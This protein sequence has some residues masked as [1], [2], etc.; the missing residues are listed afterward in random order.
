MPEHVAASREESGIQSSGGPA[1]TGSGALPF[2]S[3]MVSGQVLTSRTE[4]LEDYLCPRV[5][6]LLVVALGGAYHRGAPAR[7]TEYRLGAKFREWRIPAPAVNRGSWWSPLGLVAVFSN[8]AWQILRGAWRGGRD[9]DLFVG[10]SCFS[11][12]IGVVLKSLGWTRR[13]IY[14]SIDYYPLPSQRCFNRLMVRAFYAADRLCSRRADLVWHI[15]ARISE[16]REQYGRLPPSKYRQVEVPLCYREGIFRVLSE[17]HVERWTLGFVGTITE[18]QGLDLLLDA[19]PEIARRC[20]GIS[21]RIIGDGPYGPEFRRRAAMSPEGRRLCF[22]GFLRRE[23]DVLG[24]LGRC[25][26]GVALWPPDEGNNI[27]YADPGKPKLYLAVGLPCIITRGAE[28]AEIIHR[29]GAG[30]AIEYDVTDLVNAVMKVLGDDAAWLAFRQRAQAVGR[31]WTSEAI[32]GRGFAALTA[33]EQ[34]GAGR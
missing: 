29:E 27:R 32:L 7:C 19:M 25:A 26:A 9:F 17:E 20:P 34:G 15:T 23:E 30:V 4:T 31:R 11:G 5:D 14:Y 33:F 10:I 8:Y 6:H 1:A 13:L 28:I 22:H 24:W 12:L 18:N 2:R 3:V 16:A 21:V